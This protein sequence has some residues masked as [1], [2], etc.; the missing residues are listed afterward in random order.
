MARGISIALI[1]TFTGLMVAIPLLVIA[2][3]LK[4]RITQ[5]MF[6][7]NNDCNEMIRVIMGGGAPAEGEAAEG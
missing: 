1:C 2:F 4:A 6:E 7:I 5:V 3:F